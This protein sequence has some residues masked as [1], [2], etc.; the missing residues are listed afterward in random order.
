MRAKLIAAMP[1]LK[2]RAK[3]LVE[4]LDGASFLF[5]TRPLALDDKAKALLTD[6]AKATL[7]LVHDR[8]GQLDDWSVATTSEEAGALPRRGDAASKLGQI[9]QPLRA[10]LT[11]R[12]TS[13]PVFDVLAV[14]GREESL[15]RI[16]TRSA[17]EQVPR[18]GIARSCGIAAN[19]LP[20][21]WTRYATAVVIPAPPSGR[22]RRRLS[23][24]GRRA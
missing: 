10:A 24:Q 7:R 4:L 15:A 13:P 5:A 19:G 21:L 2:E 9:A 14:L 1:G 8:L 23:G 6:E 18:S 20:N 12:S 3:T 11:G 16:G 17:P 22:A